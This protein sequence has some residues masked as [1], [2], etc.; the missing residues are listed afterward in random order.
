MHVRVAYMQPHNERDCAD[1][2]M[3]RSTLALIGLFCMDE[4]F[5]LAQLM[6]TTRSASRE[7]ACESCGL[8]LIQAVSKISCEKAYGECKL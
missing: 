7:Q 1:C 4:V 2:I 8:S 6:Q 3:S 5:G